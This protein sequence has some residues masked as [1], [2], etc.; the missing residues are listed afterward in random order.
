MH[1]QWLALR[2]RA[3]VNA[4]VIAK[5]RGRL[6]DVGCGNSAL[7]QA[8]P[9]S[10]E[11][12]G[13][14]YPATVALGYQGRA[15][16]LCD[17]IRLPIAT[18]SADILTFLDVLEHLREPDRAIAEAARVLRTD[19][20]CL[21]RVPFLY[22]LHDEPYDYQRWTEHGLR[23]LFGES[24][25]EICELESEVAGIEAVA[26]LAAITLVMTLANVMERNRF[27]ILLSPFAVVLSTMINLAGW[28]LGRIFPKVEALPLSYRVV[29]RRA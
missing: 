22:P 15:D 16:V 7:Q 3:T 18:A 14:D 12:V 8:L 9:T 5:A 27:A 26:A 29:A 2:Q 28:G 11:Y 21:V 25:F 24:G 6:I 19:G 10:V 1:P 4:W 20:L 17:A 23:V 13:L